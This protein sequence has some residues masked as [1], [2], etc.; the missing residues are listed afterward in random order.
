MTP[1]T[2]P[3]TGTLW[4]LLDDLEM[5]ARHLLLN[6]GSARA[7]AYLRQACDR[8]AA[9]RQREA[10]EHR[11]AQTAPPDAPGDPRP[12]PPPG[13]PPGTGPAEPEAAP[14][15]DEPLTVPPGTRQPYKED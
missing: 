4:S 15:T 7:R 1:S 5:A 3:D 9:L 2:T 8:S 12:E 13:P 10:A 11:L 14:G 6:R